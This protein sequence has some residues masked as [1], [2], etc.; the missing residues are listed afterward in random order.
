[1]ARPTLN[2]HPKFAHLSGLVGGRGP[3]RGYLELIWDAA[4]ACGDPV[5]GDARKVEA[6]SDWRGARG[7]LVE[8]LVDSGF[9]DAMQ[10]D[11]NGK[12]LQTYAVH[13][14]EHHAPDY[15]LK[16]WQ[17]EA[18]RKAKGETV[19]SIRQ[20]AAA[21]RWKQ[22]D[23]NGEHVHANVRPHAPAP[24]PAQEIFPPAGA[25]DPCAAEQVAVAPEAIRE[26]VEA[27]ISED[28]APAPAFPTLPARPFA[29]AVL[30][31]WLLGTW[32]AARTAEFG[33]TGFGAGNGISSEKARDTAERLAAAPEA[34]P[35]VGDSMRKFWA[36]VKAGRHEAAAKI[37]RTPSFAFAAWFGS[38]SGDFEAAIGSAPAIPA[39]QASATGPLRDKRFGHARAE[40]SKHTTTGEVKL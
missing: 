36:D 28:D 12:H 23:A 3:A 1:M 40:D 29:G 37:A 6:V 25:C 21:Q 18:E 31:N 26:A 34:V 20:R 4:Y 32:T 17:R 14:L 5:I 24:A 33:G 22:A 8:A 27:T 19:R 2:G 10:T 39:R 16:R 11:A 15:V 7:E 30:M 35:H 9:L 38:F 13:D